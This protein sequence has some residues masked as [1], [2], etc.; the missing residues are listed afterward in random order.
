M[1]SSKRKS[2]PNISLVQ[3]TDDALALE[4]TNE[5]LRYLDSEG[6]S[7]RKSRLERRLAKPRPRRLL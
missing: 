3:F 2:P 5:A 1:T 6:L 7:H 4:F